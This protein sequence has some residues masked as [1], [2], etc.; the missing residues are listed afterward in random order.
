MGILVKFEKAIDL[1][2]SLATVVGFIS[3][4]YLVWIFIHAPPSIQVGTET[5]GVQGINIASENTVYIQGIPFFWV[6]TSLVS[7]SAGH[8]YR[9]GKHLVLE[10]AGKHYF[11]H[12]P[13]LMKA[14]QPTPTPAAPGLRQ[15]G[16]SQ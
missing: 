10:L 4:A 2:M 8:V 9:S 16:T 3:T 6:L 1:L 13:H 11:P 12:A 15:A 7:L 5:V 14:V